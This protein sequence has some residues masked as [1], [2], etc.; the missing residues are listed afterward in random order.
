MLLERGVISRRN[1]F[2]EQPSRAVDQLV[3]AAQKHDVG[4]RLE[5]IDLNLQSVWKGD[6]VGVHARQELAA[7]Q[8]DR[9]VERARQTF[10]GARLDAQARIL[11][12]EALKNLR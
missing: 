1:N 12:R 2:R 3:S 7:R 4:M 8:C 5:E 6:V 10:V 11:L 9:F